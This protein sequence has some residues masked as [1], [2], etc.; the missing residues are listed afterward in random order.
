MHE[1]TCP[2]GS[3]LAVFDPLARPDWDASLSD[4]TNACAFHGTP[5]LRTLAAAY[6]HQFHVVRVAHSGMTP[7]LALVVGLV[8]S[9]VLGRRLVGLPFSDEVP[10]LGPS[11]AELAPA[12]LAAAVSL[13]GRLKCRY[14]E[15]RGS[16]ELSAAA[17]AFSR[18][19]AHVL[20]LHRDQSDLWNRLAAPMR[21]AVRHGERAGVTV[22]FSNSRQAV[23][24]YFK[25]HCQSRRRQGSPPQPWRFFESLS[26]HVLAA[27]HGFVAL[28]YA[29]GHSEPCAGAV[30]LRHANHAIYKFGASDDRGREL[31]ANNLLMWRAIC[32]LH[33][34][35]V[36]QLHFGRTDPAQA[37]LRRFK[38]GWGAVELP[39]HYHRV[40]VASGRYQQGHG[41]RG[42]ALAG[43]FRRSPV[44]VN[45]CAGRLL[46]PHLH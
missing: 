23:A 13:A 8:C 30:F 6:G 40:T 36:R 35:D 16:R 37:G 34:G 7:G 24:R 22:T 19:F 3:S 18:Y 10:L 25:L 14:L 9:P 31:R 26:T 42:Q 2:P 17:P 32:H 4:W 20:D 44:W 39:L 27:G 28:G 1:R 12:V 33:A 38:C 46:Y 15:L 11:N 21:T 5:W 43:L 29:P 41:D 45:R